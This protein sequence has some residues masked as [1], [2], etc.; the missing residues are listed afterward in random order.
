MNKSYDVIIIGGGPGGYTAALEGVAT[1][2]VPRD[3]K[4]PSPQMDLV[5]VMRDIAVWEYIHGYSFPGEH[6]YR[7]ND[8][9]LSQAVQYLPEA[10]EATIDVIP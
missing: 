2:V 6:G 10:L 9:T 4:E 8:I 1:G 5:W 3:P 7:G